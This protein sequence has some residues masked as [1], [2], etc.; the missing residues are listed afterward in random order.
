MSDFWVF[1][2][3]S[4]MWNPGFV[5]T[6][7]ARARLNGYHRGLCVLSVVHRGTP[8]TPGLVLGLDRGG[9]CVGLA[10]RARDGES[11]AVHAYLRERE[12]VTDVYHERRLRVGLED[13][14]SVEALAFVV[15]RSHAQYAGRPD[16]E[17]IA[18]RVRAASGKAGDNREYVANTLAHMRRMDIFDREMEKV[19]RL[20][21]L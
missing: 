4:L 18:D 13:G 7:T 1:G 19:A 12:L 17:A 20:L 3:G 10:L 9:A 6:E 21:G 5:P 8:L 14:R 2:Y 16:A 11:D 15:D